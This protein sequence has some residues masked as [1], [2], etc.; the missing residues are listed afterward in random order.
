MSRAVCHACGGAVTWVR[1]PDGEKRQVEECA[2][3]TGNIALQPA[4]FG[5]PLEAQITTLRTGFRL[6]RESS[7]GLKGRRI[8]L[9][10]VTCDAPM[11]ALVGRR[12]MCAMCQTRERVALAAA[13][14][15]LIN[16]VGPDVANTWIIR[17][18][19]RGN[20]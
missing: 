5:R 1:F 13:T 2:A 10:C 11:P 7:C 16:D 9:R 15:A 8:Q 19:Q 14:A 18:I 4:L 17:A 3:G 6:H 12:S 20:R